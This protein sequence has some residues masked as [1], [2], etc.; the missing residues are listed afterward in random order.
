MTKQNTRRG[1]TQF[2]RKQI[3]TGRHLRSR[4]GFTLIELLVVLLIILVL[5]TIAW[6]SY[7]KMQEKSRAVEILLL[8]KSIATAQRLYYQTNDQW[9]PTFAQLEIEVP[10]T[11]TSA[12][13][14]P[15]GLTDTRSNAYWSL[16]LAGSRVWASRLGGD[17]QGGGFCLDL[18]TDKPTLFCVQK[19]FSNAAYKEYCNK[20]FK[21]GTTRHSG[22]G[23]LQR[24]TMP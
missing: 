4:T 19:S 17:Y 21:T 16:Q 18:A 20:F 9:A 13:Y 1:F 23:D 24:Y 3:L 14:S 6:H 22:I 2:K 11:G 12:I 7:G 10:F 8:L 5:T 15:S